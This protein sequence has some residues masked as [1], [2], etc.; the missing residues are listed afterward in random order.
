MVKSFLMDSKITFKEVN[1]AE[2]KVA[3][4]EMLRKSGRMA[5]PQIE[6]DGGIIVGFDKA[7]LKETLGL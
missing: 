2:D 5:V 6:I 3:L 7:K 1:V 4:E